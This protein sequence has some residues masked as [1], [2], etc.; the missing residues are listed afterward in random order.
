VWAAYTPLV[1][2]VAN[3]F[4][5]DSSRLHFIMGLTGFGSIIALAQSAT[6]WGLAL[7]IESLRRVP[8][9]E[10]TRR[11]QQA[12]RGIPFGIFSNIIIYALIVAGHYAYDY[13]RGFRE[14]QVRSAELET[15]L[16]RADLQN[17]KSQLQPH[18]LFNTLNTISVLMRRDPAAAN[19]TLVRL[20]DL[21][22]ISLNSVG[23]HEVSLREE[24]NFLDGYLEIEQTRFQDR[25]RIRRS[26]EP[27]AMAAAVPNLILQPLVENA[28]K[29]GI[30]KRPGPGTIE[31]V[32]KRKAS[33]LHL[34]VKDDG[35]GLANMHAADGVGLSNTRQRLQQLYGSQ[36]EFRVREADGGGVL[37]IVVIPFRIHD[38]E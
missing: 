5:P 4:R 31:I 29:H 18:F 7:A 32:A 14:R 13:Y 15:L 20:S 30:A 12:K 33:N 10:L 34:E 26:I 37:V 35:P 2:W 3:R 19:Q 17:L 8:A 28:I 6:E 11:I 24:L 36:H 23:A 21:L 9:D 22:R 38:G 1:L 25:L 27:G 16:A